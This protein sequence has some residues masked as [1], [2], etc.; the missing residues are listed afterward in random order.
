MSE[1]AVTRTK[2]PAA[3][4]MSGGTTGSYI[5]G[6]VLSL[7][8]TLTAYILVVNHV[9]SKWILVAAIG[10]LALLQFMVQLLFFLHLDNESKP[11][12]KLLAFALMFVFVLILIVGSVW[13][14]NSLNYRMNHE[15]LMQY[16]HD[17]DG[18]I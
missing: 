9:F 10:W 11:R 15:Q 6:Y 4:H 8:L 12:F 16:L 3:A 14:M 17:Q 2:K 13:V 1:P 7:I 5:T 18:G